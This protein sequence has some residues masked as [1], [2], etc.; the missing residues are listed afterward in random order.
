MAAPPFFLT[1]S[2]ITS[3]KEK[4]NSHGKKCGRCGRLSK[5]V[6]G[7]EGVRARIPIA[8]IKKGAR[9]R[10]A[11]SDSRLIRCNQMIRDR[12]KIRELIR[13]AD[14]CVHQGSACLVIGTCGY[15]GAHGGYGVTDRGTVLNIQPLNGVGIV[16]G[17]TLGRISYAN[18]FF[19]GTP[20]QNRS[21]S[22]VFSKSIRVFRPMGRLIPWR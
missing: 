14:P 4:V 22:Q 9:K 1:T 18:G 19:L 10:Q 5:S 6:L 12:L 21:V 15:V 11:S 20:V 2:I 13:N 8:T 16:A 7:D 3:A 17:P